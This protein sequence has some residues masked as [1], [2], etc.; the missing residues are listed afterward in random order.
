[1]CP[2]EEIVRTMQHILDKGKIMYW[3]TCRWSPVHIMEAFTVARQFNLTPPAVEQVNIFFFQFSSSIVINLLFTLF[4][5]TILDGISYVHSRQD[6]TLHARI[7]SQIRCRC[8]ILV[9]SFL[10]L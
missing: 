5:S 4:S 8:D 2:L 1:M 6:G 3:G 10:K 7:V 9:T